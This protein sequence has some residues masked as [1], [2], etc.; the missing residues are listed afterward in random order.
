MTTGILNGA[1][2]VDDATTTRS[3]LGVPS[4][5]GSGASGT[6]GIS[7][8]GNAAT[9]TGAQSITEATKNGLSPSNGNIYYIS[10]A[11]TFFGAFEMYEGGRWRRINPNQYTSC[12]NKT[13]ANSA[14][15]S[16]ILG[17]VTVGDNIIPAARLSVGSIIKIK[18]CGY[19]SSLSSSPGTL[20]LKAKLGSTVVFDTGAL[21]IL[22]NSSNDYWEL[23][24]ILTVQTQGASGKI[25]G[26]AKA[27]FFNTAGL[28]TANYPIVNTA[29]ISIDTT[30]SQTFD[31]T[32]TWSTA[33][34]SNVIT[35]TN[36]ILDIYN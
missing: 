33:S 30:V 20:Q 36:V 27:K 1:I 10:N 34:T 11:G 29:Q 12:A 17:T 4:T 19:Y 35:S 13:I 18:A 26:Q 28:Q 15:E 31:L 8:T 25:I 24:G 16:S 2:I 32:S 22:S 7:I 21:S 3:D 23:E 6:W 14:I 9:S 5:T